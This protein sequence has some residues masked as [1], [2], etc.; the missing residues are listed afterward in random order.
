MQVDV[1]EENLLLF[2]HLKR[3]RERDWNSVLKRT[4]CFTIASS[5]KRKMCSFGFSRVR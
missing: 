4:I 5:E 2:H 3:W 1:D